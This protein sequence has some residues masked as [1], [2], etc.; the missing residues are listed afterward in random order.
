[1]RK[2]IAVALM[3]LLT[4]ALAGCYSSGGTSGGTSGGGGTKAESVT[5]SGLA[6]QPS[7]V[8]VAVGGTVTWTNDDSAAH[9]VEGD[10]WGSSGEVAQGATFSHTFD[11]AGTYSYKC[12]IHPSMTGQVIVK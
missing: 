2:P 3:L 11:A 5:M 10:G 4:V 7:T 6:F 8:N 9:T 12:T 1:M